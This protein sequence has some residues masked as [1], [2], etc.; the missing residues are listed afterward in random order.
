MKKRYLA[1]SL[2][3]RDR[4]L[5]R[6]RDR[7][8]GVEVVAAVSNGFGGTKLL[9]IDDAACLILN[10]ELVIETRRLQ[11]QNESRWWE[12]RISVDA[13]SSAAEA[14]SAGLRMASALL[15]TSISL[16]TPKVMLRYSGPLPCDVY[17]RR[18]SG[19][20]SASGTLTLGSAPGKQFEALEAAWKQGVSTP[21][22]LLAMELFCSARFETT[23]R[24][25]FIGMVSSL[26]P[27]AVQSEYERE[28]YGSTI[29]NI[30]NETIHRL[31]S[32]KHIPS[33][34]RNSLIGRVQ[35]LNRESVRQAY[36][37]LARTYLLE[38]EVKALDEA[39]CLR[40]EML[41]AG[42]S[43]PD[44]SEVA[45]NVE[46]LVSKVFGGVVGIPCLKTFPMIM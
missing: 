5:D 23:L 43:D 22:I 19:G 8:Y 13:F 7:P 45:Q 21:R 1:A 28:E 14:E 31:D 25:R 46:G 36:L 26:E 2:S 10:D 24:S 34:I 11:N 6:K 17:D 41:H 18:K 3:E 42:D 20:F 32:S 33:T 4:I 27:L 35:D 39:Y 16:G 30:I 29:K 37:R 15:W 9:G 38:G 12:Y 40:S 44:L